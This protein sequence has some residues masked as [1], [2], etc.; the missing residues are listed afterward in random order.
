MYKLH[1]DRDLGKNIFGEES[2]EIR[3]WIVNAIA[4]I[5]IVDGVIEKHEFVALQE[6]IELL[7]SRDE[8][9][10]L[11]KKVKERDLYEIKDIK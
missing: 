1:I 2:K 3:D 6:A 10:D 7:E 8:V 9:H 11:M 4:S 5:V